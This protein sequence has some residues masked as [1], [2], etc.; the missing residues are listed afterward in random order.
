MLQ[1]T[2]IFVLPKFCQL[3]YFQLLWFVK[4]VCLSGVETLVDIQSTVCL[5][6]KSISSL[7][8]L[9]TASA[10]TS[11]FLCLQCF[12]YPPMSLFGC[13]W[14]DE[15]LNSLLCT[16]LMQFNTFSSSFFIKN[17]TKK[18]LLIIPKTGSQASE[19]VRHEQILC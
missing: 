4:W 10:V 11:I 12:S 3:F 14:K 15:S 13:K 16:C 19:Y 6:Q 17:K 2:E 7:G 9:K 18:C 8:L 5:Q 1:H